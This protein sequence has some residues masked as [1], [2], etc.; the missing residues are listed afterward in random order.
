MQGS[1]LPG[2]IPGTISIRGLSTL[3]N[4]APLVIVDGMEQS[5]TDI[6]P[7]QIKSINVLKDAASAAIYGTRGASGVILLPQRRVRKEK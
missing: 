7:N 3:Q 4:A 5:L 2:S 6:D 1:N